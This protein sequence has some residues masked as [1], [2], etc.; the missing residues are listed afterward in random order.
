MTDGNRVLVIDDEE[1]IRN[2]I[3]AVLTQAGYEVSGAVNGAEGL[4]IL[5]SQ[6][7][8]LVITDILMPDKEGIETII[9]IRKARPQ[10]HIVAISGGGRMQ[11]LYPLGIAEKIGA[12]ATLAKPFEVE[13]LLQVVQKVVTT[14]PRNE[15]AW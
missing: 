2:E 9:G 1:M 11:N 8:D 14:P 10:S 3:M 4:K 5:A 12:D 15:P 13:D 6:P 7:I